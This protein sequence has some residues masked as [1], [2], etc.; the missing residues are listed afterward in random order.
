MN[1]DIFFNSRIHALPDA[2]ANTMD[3]ILAQTNMMG[4][5]MLMGRNPSAPTEVMTML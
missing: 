4:F 2:I 1:T 3:Q 5:V